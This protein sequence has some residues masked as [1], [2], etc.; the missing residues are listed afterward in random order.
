MRLRKGLGELEIRMEHFYKNCHLCPRECGVNRLEGQK[1]YCHAG[2]D[3]RVA[4]AAP[5]FWEEPCISGRQGSGAVFFSGC[6]MGC[7]YCQNRE[8]AENHIGKEITVERLSEVFLELQ[9]KGVHNINLVTPDHYIPSVAWAL[10]A[11]KKQGLF[12]PIVCN[13]SGYEKP[14]TLRLLDGLAD[15]YLPDFKYM[16]AEAAGKYSHAPDYPQIAKIAL[17]EMVRQAGPPVFDGEGLIKRGVIVRHLLLPGQLKNSKKVLKYLH[18]TYGNKI[19]IS[20][21]SQYT[22]LPGVC[23]YPEINRRITPRE[24]RKLLEY[25]AE[26][27]IE[28]G[29][30]QDME[31]AEESFIPKFDLEGVE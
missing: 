4:R 1:G 11:A 27:G 31:T 6:A 9:E 28:N 23:G 17:E 13:C 26:L 30:M 2:A 16:D 3:L 12:L 19:Y 14:E 18:C 5:H 10:Q 25:A 7:V 15:I 20:M 21:M 8:I 29:F 22:P 24:Y